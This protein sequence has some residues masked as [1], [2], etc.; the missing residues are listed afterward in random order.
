MFCINDGWVAARKMMWTISLQP[1]K[2]AG[3]LQKSKDGSEV[4]A[5]KLPTLLEVGTD[6]PHF[7]QPLH[8]LLPHK[9]EEMHTF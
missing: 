4:C 3:I 7:G 8:L 5:G 9:Y 6:S 1:L 2:E